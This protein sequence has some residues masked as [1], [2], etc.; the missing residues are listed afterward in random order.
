MIYRIEFS[1][2][3]YALLPFKIDSIEKNI[4]FGSKNVKV[5]LRW[6]EKLKNKIIF[7]KSLMEE[8]LIKE[9]LLYQIILGDSIKIGPLIGILVDKRT[10]TLKDNL[11]DYISYFLLYSGFH[12]VV[13]LFALDGIDF[14]RGTVTGFYFNPFSD[15]NFIY[16][17][18]PLPYFIFRRIGLN[19]NQRK[20]LLDKALLYNSYYFDKWEFYNLIKDKVNMPVTK[21]YNKE[22]LQFML[23]QYKEVF[24]KKQNGS[25]GI[26]IYKIIKSQKEY[27]LKGKFDRSYSSYKSLDDLM[28]TLN[29]KGYLIQRAVKPIKYENRCSDIRVVMQKD[30]TL[31]WKLTY[32]IVCLGKRDGICSNYQRFGYTLKFEEFFADKLGLGYHKIFRIKKAIEEECKKVCNLMDTIGNFCDVGIDVIVDEDYNIWIIEANKRHDHRMVLSLNDKIG[33]YQI[34]GNPIKFGVKKSG[35]EL[36]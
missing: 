8:L 17:T 3:R 19:E 5:K 27:M 9:K 18:L 7:P 16:D 6:D 25:M 22:N 11:D 35:F 34:K 23:N 10:E 30:D 36:F 21:I 28:K 33:Y 20:Y 32:M 14:K 13:F 29:L 31:K 12:G 1:E 26:D 2:D 15:N 4:Y 24:L